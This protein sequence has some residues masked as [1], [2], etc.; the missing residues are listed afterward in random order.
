MCVMCVWGG[1]GLFVSHRLPQY[2]CTADTIPPPHHCAHNR[3]VSSFFTAPITG[4]HGVSATHESKKNGTLSEDDTVNSDSHHGGDRA[5]GG[6]GGGGGADSVGSP[7]VDLPAL[8]DRMDEEA[9]EELVDLAFAT[10]GH[11]DT[12]SMP[13]DDF[14]R[15]ASADTTMSAWFEAMA[16]V[17]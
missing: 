11:P 16:V 10:A 12:D 8:L 15:W 5:S 1:K 2:P 4:S 6:G 3:P 13:F 9:I 17:F 7:H 14:Q